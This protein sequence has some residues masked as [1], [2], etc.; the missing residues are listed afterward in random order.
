M[1]VWWMTWDT[2]IPHT[3][4]QQVLQE[5]IRENGREYNV[6]YPLTDTM[7]CSQS[8]ANSAENSSE[9]KIWLIN[10]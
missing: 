7:I 9:G 1:P 3:G 5:I 4:Q 6:Q 8:Q 2:A 10:I